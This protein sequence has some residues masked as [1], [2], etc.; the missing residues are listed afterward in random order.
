[1]LS[2]IA[3]LAIPF[4]AGFVGA[5]MGVGG[6]IIVVPALV[7]L[8][9]VPPRLAIG[10]S[11]VAV[12]ATSSAA[13][14]VYVRD[15]LS[16]LRLGILAAFVTVLGALVGVFA[17]KVSGDRLVLSVFAAVL[18]AAAWLLWRH[19]EERVARP[20]SSSM[21]ERAFSLTGEYEDPAA[22]ET[23]RYGVRHVLLGLASMFGAGLI[24]GMLGVGGGIFQVPLMVV[25][26]GL[27]MKA[28][29][30]TSNFMMGI[31]A[32]TGATAYFAMGEVHP[33][34]AGPVTV[35][36]FFGSM[37]GARLMP[38]VKDARL[39]AMFSALLVALAFVMATKALQ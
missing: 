11:M 17:G 20:G 34:I 36:V 22:G 14:A 31:T 35:G 9:D 4:A 13:A 29:T 30:A 23:V 25:L 3:L 10:A 7:G 38:R 19:P 16:N 18:I 8:L 21:F 26:M 28:A 27:P 33:K 37:L 1:M 6:G 39:K 2:V 32:A 24:S 12:V 5:M 15:R